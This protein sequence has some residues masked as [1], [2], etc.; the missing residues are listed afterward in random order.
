[1]GSPPA[2]MAAPRPRL[3]RIL[4]FG[5]SLTAGYSALGA[6]HHPYHGRMEQMLAMAFPHVRVEVAED[7]ESGETVTH[8]FGG[9]MEARCG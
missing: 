2:R 9:R 1:M 6:V 7:G 5:D 8:M 4:C 3:L